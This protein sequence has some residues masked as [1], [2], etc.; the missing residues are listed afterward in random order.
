MATRGSTSSHFA[1]P[2]EAAIGVGCDLE[3]WA[4][5]LLPKNTQYATRSL[6]AQLRQAYNAGACGRFGR[7]ARLHLHS[8]ADG[9]AWLKFKTCTRHMTGGTRR[10]GASPGSCCYL[11]DASHAPARAENGQCFVPWRTMCEQKLYKELW[12][13]HFPRY[14]RGRQSCLALTIR[15]TAFRSLNR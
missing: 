2:K 14:L 15:A 9:R 7:G 5:S 12:S 6:N 4:M 8:T 1:S 10:C 3:A 13:N 11:F